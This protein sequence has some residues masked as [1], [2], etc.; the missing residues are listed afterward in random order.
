MVQDTVSTGTLSL[1][2][3]QKRTDLRFLIYRSLGSFWHNTKRLIIMTIQEK[4]KRLVGRQKGAFPRNHRT[5]RHDLWSN[6]GHHPPKWAGFITTF[7]H[8]KQ[9]ALSVLAKSA[10]DSI[11]T[12]LSVLQPI[13]SHCEQSTSYHRV[14]CTH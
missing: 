9:Q 11:V 8:C 4:E 5:L 2:A 1:S 13:Q 7:L 14:N 12:T 10:T 6:S 3:Q